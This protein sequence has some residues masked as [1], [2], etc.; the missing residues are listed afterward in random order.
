MGD[1]DLPRSYLKFLYDRATGWEADPVL[2]DGIA[3]VA[4]VLA[5]GC[6]LFV[7][8]RDLRRTRRDARLGNP[9]S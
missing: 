6:S 8:V 4:F 3:A 5:V 7:N 1:Y 9:T 2:V